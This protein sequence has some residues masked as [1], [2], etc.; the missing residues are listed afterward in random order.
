MTEMRITPFM[1]L[2]RTVAPADSMAMTK[3]LAVASAMW[4]APSRRGS[5]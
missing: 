4:L 1:M 2:G 5:V 3:G